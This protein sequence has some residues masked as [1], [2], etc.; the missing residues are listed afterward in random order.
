MR[1]AL[2]QFKL[3]SSGSLWGGLIHTAVGLA[4]GT[5]GNEALGLGLEGVIEGPLSGG[6]DVVGTM[7]KCGRSGVVC[8]VAGG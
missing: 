7:A 4:G 8:G 2:V 1:Q 6:M 5:G 3:G